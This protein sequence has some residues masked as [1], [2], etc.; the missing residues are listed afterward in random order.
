MSLAQ[1][2]A[3]RTP[4]LAFGRTVVFAGFRQRGDNQDPVFARFDG[5]RKVYCRH[6]EQEPPDG[7]AVGLTWDGGR[8]AYVLYTVVGGGTA[9]EAPARRGWLQRYGDGGGS[10][11]VT[12]LGRVELGAGTLERATF[13]V[14]RLRKQGTDK[15][16][17]IVPVASP[18]VTASG[19]V[20][21]RARSAFSPLN[22]DRSRMCA[23]G[24]EYPSP[25]P[26][27]ADGASYVGMFTAD[28]GSLACARTWGCGNVRRPCPDAT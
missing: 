26:G 13:L 5:G 17:T 19:L 10:S 9:L 23:P 15:T 8:T 11:A 28:L 14:A 21:V 6:H 22:P 24:S 1:L 12:V 25:Q 3:S 20:A 7:R 16:N 27:R 4:R 18:V 2:R